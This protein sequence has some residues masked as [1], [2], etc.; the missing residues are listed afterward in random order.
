VLSHSFYVL[1]QQIWCVCQALQLKV[2]KI[3]SFALFLWSTVR[4][5]CTVYVL[6]HNV[7]S[8]CVH[9]SISLL[10]PQVLYFPKPLQ[11]LFHLFTHPVPPLP[12]FL[13]LLFLSSLLP[14]PPL[15]LCHTLSLSPSLHVC[16]RLWPGWVAGL[17]SEMTTRHSTL[18]SW[19]P[20]GGCSSSCT[21]RD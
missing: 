6:M 13:S 2:S 11:F 18:G 17:T 16:R 12:F 5:Q 15:P 4:V 10:L 21:T 20:S 19:R 7:S 1:C 14:P 8:L 3:R 9:T